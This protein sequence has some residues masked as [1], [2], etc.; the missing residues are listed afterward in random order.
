MSL[1]SVAVLSLSVVVAVSGVSANAELG[2]V[3]PPSVAD[4]RDRVERR[5]ARARSHSSPASR[6]MDDHCQGFYDAL[7]GIGADELVDLVRT[8]AIECIRELQWGPSATI[9]SAAA[10]VGNVVAAAEAIPDALGA[11][12]GGFGAGVRRLFVFLR[13]V[14]DIR[15]WCLVRPSVDPSG[16][17][18]E[19]V[20]DGRRP[21]DIGPGTDVYEA[22]AAAVDTFRGHERLGDASAEHAAVLLE[23]ARTIDSYQQNGRHL[24]FVVYW[25]DRWGAPYTDMPEFQDFAWYLVLIL[26]SG[27]RQPGFGDAFGEHRALA[28]ALRDCALSREWLGTPSQWIAEQCGAEVGRFTKYPETAN[29]VYAR[30][31]IEALRTAYEGDE[32]ARGI[33]LRLVGEV[34][35]NDAGNCG[36]YGLCHWYEGDGFAANFRAALFVE[37]LQ[38]PVSHCP[39]DRVTVHA[40]GLDAGQVALAC[41]Q[42]AAHGETFQEM[43]G[44]DCV[45]VPDDVN[46]H[47]DIYV[48]KDILSCEDLSWHA[49]WNGVDACSGIYYELDPADPDTRSLFIATEFEAWENPPD[50][51]LNIWNF[52]HEYAHYL[53]GRYNIHGGYAPRDSTHW[54]TEGFAEYFAAEVSPYIDLWSYASPHTLTDI[55]L[56]SGSLPTRYRHRHMAVRYFMENHR[57]FVDAMLGHLRSGDFDAYQAFLEGEVGA[58]EDDWEIW[59]RF[60]GKRRSPLEVTVPFV[61]STYDAL[62][63]HGV[64][65]IVNRSD[66]ADTVGIVAVDDAGVRS[67]PLELAIGANET[68]HL[69]SDDL[70]R[71]N[72]GKGLTGRVGAGRGDWAL[73]LMAAL[74]IEALSYVRTSDGLLAAM[75]DTVVRDGDTYRVAFFNPASNRDQESLLRLRNPGDEE[76]AVMIAGV[77]DS[78]QSP[79]GMVTLHLPAGEARMLSA[80]ELEEGGATGTEGSLGDG[81]GKWR[82]DVRSAQPLTVMS[83][84]SSVTGHLKNLSTAP[85]HGAKGAHLVPFFP[86]ASNA[87]GRQGFVR[88][89][90]RSD[91]AGEVSIT[92]FDVTGRAHE[93][94]TL[95]IGAGEARHFN[96]DDLETGNPQRWLTGGTGAGEGDWRLD[97]ESDLDI[98]VLAYVRTVDGFLAAIHDVAPQAENLHHVP[99][100]NPADDADARSLLRLVNTGA[101]NVVVHIEG[102][103]DSGAAGATSFGIP[104]GVTTT[105]TASEL[106]RDGLG[107]GKDKW[108]L[109]VFVTPGS[110][111]EPAAESPFVAMSLLSGA[112]GYLTN[113]STAPV[114][115]V[116]L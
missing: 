14:E 82:L 74:D 18:A 72:V 116:G 4:D 3:A 58:Y 45:P 2:D 90:N 51:D 61:L 59:R 96:S 70:E 24:D 103:D 55:V 115:R 17:C 41:D 8:T 87:Y 47:L 112:A 54:W 62:D 67:A 68:V 15:H 79:G 101:E 89:I 56:H 39:A 28:D 104:A 30:D 64:V 106:E 77:D 114:R 99:I 38:C 11:Y 83:L 95:S 33:W 26:Y 25:L 22:V 13:M 81:A 48:F 88:V 65:R 105:V 9:Q 108:R 102:V 21:W 52:E 109:Y 91:R 100:F 46:D 113:L 86:A 85:R 40:E 36:V 107:D 63:R 35:Y 50:P 1:R 29:Y 78:G 32:A 57:D 84:V 10:R 73:E 60:G 53:D 111:A 34:N 94:A 23:T 42:L 110:G 76:A 69:T 5:T 43:F 7:P 93:P 16:T 31:L 98:A 37:R 80:R 75:H 92:A 66:V 20:W 12:D 44:T 49:F 97:L 27:H 6:V 19:D 71:G